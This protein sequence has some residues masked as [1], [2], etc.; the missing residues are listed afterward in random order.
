VTAGGGAPAPRQPG[1]HLFVVIEGTDGSGKT[2]IRKHIFTELRRRGTDVL[3]T[4]GYYWLEPEH[5]RI[6][7]DARF[8]GVRLP[9]ETILAAYVGDKEL[10]SERLIGPHLRHRNVICDRYVV[11][12]M[13][14]QALTWRMPPE[15][16]Y[17]RYLAS[18]V[19]RPD[20]VLFIDTPPETSVRRLSSRPA[21]RR[22]PWEAYEPLVRAYRVFRRLL[23]S[24]EFPG[25]GPVLRI[26]NTGS[27]EETLARVLAEVTSRLTP[28][29][30]DR[31][32]GGPAAGRR[33]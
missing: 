27:Q 30:A 4:P 20:L 17:R 9:D 10:L 26:D 16:T 32:A 15:V 1:D 2:T 18:A 21:Q 19:R 22:H 3:S 14:Q 12:D 29:P 7:V 33:P 31:A 24:G 6:I 23:V 25:F 11:S 5:T 13:V 28:G 8:H